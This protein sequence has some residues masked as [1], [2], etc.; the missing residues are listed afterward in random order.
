M[1]EDVLIVLKRAYERNLPLWHAETLEL[2]VSWLLPKRPIAF[3]RIFPH[4]GCHPDLGYVDHIELDLSG[5]AVDLKPIARRP[6]VSGIVRINV[7]EGERPLAI[8]V[9]DH[10]IIVI[11]PNRLD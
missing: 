4:F 1:G 11:H 2:I 6:C 7:Q 5:V 10:P 3:H 8:L 9:Q